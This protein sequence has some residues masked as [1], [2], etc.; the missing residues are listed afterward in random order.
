MATSYS[1]AGL[2]ALPSELRLQIYDL[3][4]TTTNDRWNTFETFDGAHGYYISHSLPPTHRY[5]YRGNFSLLQ[6]CWQIRHEVLPILVGYPHAFDCLQDLCEWVGRAPSQLL[7]L[8]REVHVRVAN[9]SLRWMSTSQQPRFTALIDGKKES[10]ESHWI[11]RHQELLEQE[12]DLPLERSWG[13]RMRPTLIAQLADP[14][15]S[16]VYDLVKGPL[17][18]IPV[19]D[20]E[21]AGDNVVALLW[22]TFKAL[23]NIRTLRISMGGSHHLIP[24]TRVADQQ[25]LLLMCS[26]AMPSLQHLSLVSTPLVWDYFTSFRN[27]RH[28]AI[29]GFGPGTSADALAALHALPHLIGLT[30]RWSSAS[31]DDSQRPNTTFNKFLFQGDAIA[32]L[33]PLT[34][35]ELICD[36]RDLSHIYFDV[37][38]FHALLAHKASLRDFRIDSRPAPDSFGGAMVPPQSFDAILELIKGSQIR[39]LTLSLELMHGWVATRGNEVVD[40]LPPSV[41]TFNIL[42][43]VPPASRDGRHSEL[44][45]T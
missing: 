16:P 5:K 32:K 36:N 8:V 20:I 2:L 25:L 9:R 27:L 44:H 14:F 37:P 35:F 15:L 39:H 1:G 43:K 45:I 38:I 24:M 31:N 17:F 30:L 13:N 11:Q 18:G 29:S 22:R 3:I 6:V 41:Q 12:Y 42:V 28:L 26:A 7:P 23:S 40:V 19:S 21:R 4:L 34:K 33:R 10:E